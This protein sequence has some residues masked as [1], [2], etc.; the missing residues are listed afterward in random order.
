MSKSN[1]FDLPP[2]W[3]PGYAVPQNVIDEG[4]ERHGYVTEWAPRGSFDNPKVGYAGYAVPAYVKQE[5][6]GQGAMSTR[7]APRGSYAG[8]KVQHWLDHQTSNVVGRKRLPGGATQMQIE[9]LSGT[10]K[11]ATGGT[12]PFTAYGMKMSKA[13]LETVRMMPPDE[14]KKQLKRVLDRVDPNLWSRADQAATLEVKAG[15]PDAI[16]LQRGLAAAMSLGI[17][18]ELVDLGKGKLPAKRSQ[19]GAVCYPCLALGD[20]ASVPQV[21]QCDASGKKIWD[22]LPDGTGYWR[23]RKASE[24]CKSSS[25]VS[26][27]TTTHAPN[28]LHVGPF[29]I[30]IENGV[31]RDSSPLSADKKAWVDSQVA[32][33]AKAGGISV[34]EVQTGK[35]PFAKFKMDGQPWSLHCQVTKDGGVTIAYYKVPAGK[36]LSGLGVVYTDPLTGQQIDST[37]PSAAFGATWQPGADSIFTNIAN[38]VWDV[39]VSIWSGISWV[40]AEVVNAVEDAVQFVA[41]A[42][43]SLMSSSVGKVAAAAGGAYLGGAA[44][45]QAGA[46]GAQVVAGA[47]APCSQGQVMDPTTKKCVTPPPPQS[48][49]IGLMPILLIGGAGL[50]AVLLLGKKKQP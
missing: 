5:P 16:A 31:W 25:S 9:T 7:W 8:P 10:E 19:L 49:G 22:K 42:A 3:N 26:I 24:V 20:T 45:A 12:A 17:A 11:R 35:Y 13:L 48:D 41:D 36:G 50:A 18:S 6:Y 34:A 46:L 2:P 21:G 38:A 44:G 30:P 1:P 23:A 47:C 39:L 32:V 28:F 4:L 15:V 27:T 14:R 40:A 43:C 29:L 37:K 33:A